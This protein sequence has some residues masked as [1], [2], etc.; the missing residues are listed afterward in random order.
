M[1]LPFQ[2]SSNWQSQILTF[3]CK[4]LDVDNSLEFAKEFERCYHS[5]IFIPEVIFIT[6]T[7]VI[8][9]KFL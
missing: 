1:L 6:V 2:L 9:A 7:S 3:F 8:M 5:C 4:I